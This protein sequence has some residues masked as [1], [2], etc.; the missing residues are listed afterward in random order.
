MN[1]LRSKKGFTL[2]EII[3][4]LVIIAI[5]AAI[6]LPALTGYIKDANEKAAISEGRTVWVAMQTI[7]STMIGE[8]KTAAEIKDH[9]EDANK[10]R[11]DV[12]EL[13]G[14]KVDAVKGITSVT[15][16]ASGT[17]DAFIYD[18]SG[19]TPIYY[20]DGSLHTTA[21]TAS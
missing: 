8:G 19:T 7:S 6:S 14:M 13:T 10:G 3:V 4:V 17:V 20:Y 1:F 15:I 5:L 2:V 21:K 18:A 9:F 11:Q 12:A 16:S